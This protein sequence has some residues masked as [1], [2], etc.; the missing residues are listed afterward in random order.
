MLFTLLFRVFKL[1]SNFERFHHET[2]NLKDIFKRNGYPR[3]FIDG[4]IKRFLSKNFIDKKVYDL[5]PKKGFV[6]VLPLI[7][8][9]TM[10]IKI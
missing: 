9:K 5:A 7:E 6:C 4:C 10:T 3:N 8:K 1:C 2:L